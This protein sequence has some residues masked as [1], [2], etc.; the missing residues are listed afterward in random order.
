MSRKQRDERKKS[1]HW[2]RGFDPSKPKRTAY[3][4]L[5]D[6][7]VRCAHCLILGFDALEPS[8]LMIVPTLLTARTCWPI[9]FVLS[10]WYVLNVVDAPLTAAV[11]RNVD[12]PEL[13]KLHSELGSPIRELLQGLIYSS[14]VAS[15]TDQLGAASDSLLSCVDQG[16]LLLFARVLFSPNYSAIAS[17]MARNDYRHNLNGMWESLIART[18]QNKGAA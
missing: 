2:Y 8:A 13:I 18:Q 7:S 4:H 16:A 1:G 5:L 6:A 14:Y 15:D 17:W 3:E 12:C 10:S 9:S 11:R